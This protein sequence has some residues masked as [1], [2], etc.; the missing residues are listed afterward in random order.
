MEKKSFKNTESALISDNSLTN[1]QEIQNRIFAIRGMQVMLDRDLANLYNVTTKRLNEQVKRNIKRFP[2][3]FR[4]QL[5]E[6]EFK[7]LEKS[8]FFSNVPLNMKGNSLRSQNATSKTNRGGR[9]YLPYVFTEQG[10]SMLSAVLKSNTA[11]EIS[12]KIINTF[13]QMRKFIAYNAKE[14][15]DKLKKN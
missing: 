3:C 9:R 11:I 13:V 7:I 14:L 4:F 12:I 2:D 8:S 10:V 6:N 15:I 1:Y 5:T